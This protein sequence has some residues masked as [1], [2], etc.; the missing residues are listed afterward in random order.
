MAPAFAASGRSDGG[1]VRHGCPGAAAVRARRARTVLDDNHAVDR[2]EHVQ[3][4]RHE[5]A[6]APL[7]LPE[8]ALVHHLRTMDNNI[9]AN[10]NIGA[11]WTTTL[12]PTKRT[13][14]PG[15]LFRS[16]G[17]LQWGGSGGGLHV[18]PDVRIERAHDVVE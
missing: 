14:T 10:N 2:R 16:R 7:E 15:G 5:D 12:G 4:V 18:L 6:R 17:G 8:D 3:F 1:G 13:E 9:G 11:P